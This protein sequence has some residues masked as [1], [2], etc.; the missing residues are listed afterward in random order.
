MKAE[1]QPDYAGFW[2]RAV[3]SFINNVLI[4]AIIFYGSSFFSGLNL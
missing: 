2:I 3:A 4:M 1:P